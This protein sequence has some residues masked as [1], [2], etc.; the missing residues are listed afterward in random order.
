[1]LFY[2]K[3]PLQI[4]QFLI[5]SCFLLIACCTNAQTTYIPLGAKD[6]T[7]LDRLEIKTRLEGLTFS[8]VKPYP[9]RQVIQTAELIDSLEQ[10]APGSMGLTATD[11]ENLLHLFM[12]N[13]E[14][15]KPREFYKSRKPVFGDR[16][17]YQTKGNLLEVNNKDLFLA[18]NPIV[19]FTGGKENNNEKILYQNT[20]GLAVR[21][22]ISRRVGFNISFTDNQ[23]RD[24]L[25]VN[26]WIAEHLAVPGA[27]NYKSTAYGVVGGV[28]DYFDARGS[29]TFNVAKYIDMQFGYDKNFIGNGFRSLYL[30]DFSNNA[31][32][33]KINTRIW[34]FNYENLFFELYDK[35]DPSGNNVFP[36]KYA[37]INY[38]NI[39]ATK[40]L[41]VG[42]FE[43][44][45][46]GRQNHFDIQYMIP[47]MFIRPAE[48]NLGSGDNSMV[49][50]D[51]K[52]NLAHTVQVY[53]Q[54]LFDELLL[55]N[56]IS[57]NGWWA[58]KQG[59]QLGIK[60]ID[61]FHVKNLDLQAE[62]N[63]VRPY[64]Y[65]HYDTV[66]NYAH[67][68]QPLAHPLGAN[69]KEFIGTLKWQPM[70][71]LYIQLTGIHYMQ[72]LD[73]GG[74]N[75]GYWPLENYLDR[76]KDANGVTKD[77]GY[78]IGDGLKVNTNILQGVVSY[79]LR[80]NM[81]IDLTGFY[82]NYKPET[83][84]AI[85][86]TTVSLSLRWNIG[87]REFMF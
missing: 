18:V 57:K 52:A 39:N 73:S 30:S 9:R 1:M 12:N 8:S 80:E 56:W 20:R 11:R 25:Y 5:S 41:N 86:T 7:V 34:K 38:L 67:Y 79:E 65:Q 10:V 14:W 44:V 53:G 22:M 31:T 68:N 33:L 28:A 51:A 35:H 47:V 19:Y 81:F 27:G 43:S 17:I 85:N 45:V 32:F 55:K 26:S 77:F 48:S 60:Y 82:R 49:G 84:D 71:K 24:P 78:R 6:Y 46:F 75:Y 63:I 61:A 76:V 3:R 15:S 23:E 69:F 16:G 21:G 42:A 70:Q 13:S 74:V 50:F 59:Y 54:I 64:T 4:M 40:W 83:G 58:N 36:R 2:G 29:V 87:R 66:A 62:M 37:R 72:G